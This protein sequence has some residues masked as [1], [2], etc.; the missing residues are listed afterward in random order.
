MA[1][2]LVLLLLMLE[3]LT[4]TATKVSNGVTNDGLRDCYHCHL[5]LSRYLLTTKCLSLTMFTHISAL[6][7]MYTG[8]NIRHYENPIPYPCTCTNKIDIDQLLS[9]CDYKH[10]TKMFMVTN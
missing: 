10:S 9:P 6:E 8:E 2:V 1:L 4:W 5:C 3:I 7:N